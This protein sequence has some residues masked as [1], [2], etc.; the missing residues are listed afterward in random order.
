MR[1]SLIALDGWINGV[2]YREIALA[3]HGPDFVRENWSQGQRAL[4]DRMVRLV[5]RGRY[6][7]DGGYRD[8]LR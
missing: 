1:N 5:R 7:M 2:S 4:K 8:L 6:L 3:I